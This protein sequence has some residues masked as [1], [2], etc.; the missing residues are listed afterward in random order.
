[1][2]G[3]STIKFKREYK[4][5]SSKKKQSG[6]SRSRSPLTLCFVSLQIEKSN[7]YRDLER[8]MEWKESKKE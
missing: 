2:Y 4:S 3:M 7:F 1:M 6:V 8:V 5:D